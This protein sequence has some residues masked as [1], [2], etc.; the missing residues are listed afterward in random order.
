M[1]GHAVKSVGTERRSCSHTPGAV[2]TTTLHGEVRSGRATIRR[3]A[4][5]ALRQGALPDDVGLEF[6]A[7]RMRGRCPG[8]TPG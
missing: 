2:P 4:G 5:G 1:I 3:S 6:E 8:M 7:F